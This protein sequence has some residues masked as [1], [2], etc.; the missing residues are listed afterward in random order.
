MQN[1]LVDFEALQKGSSGGPKNLPGPGPNGESQG[2]GA[3]I[4]APSQPLLWRIFFSIWA[5]IQVTTAEQ[6]RECTNA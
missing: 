1:A 2:F 3:H 4:A 5:I 6:S